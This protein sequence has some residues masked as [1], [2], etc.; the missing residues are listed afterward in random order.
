MRTLLM[1]LVMAL[2]AVTSV[3][4]SCAHARPATGNHDPNAP[5]DPDYPEQNCNVNNTSDCMP[6]PAG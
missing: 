6:A 5:L 2:L 4:A 1:W 3:G